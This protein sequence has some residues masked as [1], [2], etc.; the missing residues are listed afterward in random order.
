MSTSK[1]TFLSKP[2]MG[3]SISAPTL[4]YFRARNRRKLHSLVLKE[5]RDS[6]ITQAELCLRLRKDPATISRML[7]APGNWGL[8][9]AS[10]LLFAIRGGEPSYKVEYPLDK[11]ARN[12]GAMA[13]LEL[14]TAASEIGSNDNIG[15]IKIVTMPKGV[16][17]AS[18]SPRAA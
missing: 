18:S 2:A 11:P 7:G 14:T 12:H 17:L 13:Q 9:T 1:T 3:A 16:G 8:D 10:D 4:A 5:F 15:T 6:G